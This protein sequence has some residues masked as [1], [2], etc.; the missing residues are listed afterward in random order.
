MEHQCSN[1]NEF[2]PMAT[3]MVICEFVGFKLSLVVCRTITLGNWDLWTNHC[4]LTLLYVQRLGHFPNCSVWLNRVSM[5]RCTL[6]ASVIFELTSVL[7][8]GKLQER[9]LLWSVLWMR[10]RYGGVQQELC[11]CVLS[12]AGKTDNITH[13]DG[14]SELL[15]SKLSSWS[16]YRTFRPYYTT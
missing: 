15:L 10:D 1:G 7:M 16:S 12:N 5:V 3:K 8:N 13:T 6:M 9:K 4:Y 14:R 11:L 2:K